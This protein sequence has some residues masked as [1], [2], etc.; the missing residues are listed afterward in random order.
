MKYLILSLWIS[1]HFNYMIFLPIHQTCCDF[2]EMALFVRRVREKA[3]G[4]NL[5]LQGGAG[6]GRMSRK[7]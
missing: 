7:L 1:F 2:A 3:C 4:R 6:Y 5:A